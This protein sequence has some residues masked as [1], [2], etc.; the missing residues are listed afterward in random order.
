MIEIPNILLKDYFNFM[1][2][3]QMH[4]L[5]LRVLL[6]YIDNDQVKCNT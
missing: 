2:Q 3:N 1:I 6:I 5:L 4:I